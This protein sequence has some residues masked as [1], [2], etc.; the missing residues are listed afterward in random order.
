MCQPLPGSAWAITAPKLSSQLV[1]VFAGTISSLGQNMIQRGP[2]RI[3]L[4]HLVH[5]Q[6]NEAPELGL[7]DRA[8][9]GPAVVNVFADAAILHQ[10]RAF[11]PSQMRRNTGLAHSEDLLEFGDGEFSGVEEMHEP[12]T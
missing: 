4:Q 2:V 12:G 3:S 8:P 10:T 6:S 1:K 11:E 7:F 9:T 5:S